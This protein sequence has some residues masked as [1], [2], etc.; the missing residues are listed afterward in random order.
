MRSVGLLYMWRI[1][2][3][4][5]WIRKSE[6]A[7]RHAGLSNCELAHNSL[8]RVALRVAE[9]L[10]GINKSA[11]AI[12]Y[13]GLGNCELAYNAIGRVARRL[14]DSGLSALGTQIGQPFPPC[15]AREMRAR[16]YRAL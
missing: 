12:R 1:V 10:I 5:N 16:A 2:D 13:T 11:S 8:G 15:R 4:M 6:S 7:F 14:T 3:Y 9:Y